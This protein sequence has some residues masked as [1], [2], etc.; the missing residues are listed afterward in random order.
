MGDISAQTAR[1]LGVLSST[2]AK[3]NSASDQLNAALLIIEKRLVAMGLGLITWVPI[4][5]TRE[6]QDEIG[7]EYT[8]IHL[9]F[10]KV[11]ENWGLYTRDAHFW[12]EPDGSRW[13]YSNWKPLTRSPREVRL[14]AVPRIPDL[15]AH[16]QNEANEILARVSEAEAVAFADAPTPEV[17]LDLLVPCQS[18]DAAFVFDQLSSTSGDD[19]YIGVHVRTNSLA[20]ELAYLCVKRAD[21]MLALSTIIPEEE[22]G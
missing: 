1:L 10:D 9:G 8:E 18:S 14:Q 11:S 13:E 15:L 3:L 22:E 6:Y 19:E 4:E 17:D 21:L 2:A 5:G 7:S 16:L 12:D 20:R